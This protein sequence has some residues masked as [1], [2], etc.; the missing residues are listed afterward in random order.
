MEFLRFEIARRLRQPMVWIFFAVNFLLILGALNSENITV[1]ADLHNVNANAPWVVQ[2]Y[3]II[4]TLIGLLITTAFMNTAAV[5]DFAD[6]F[7][8]ILF[9][10][11][12]SK[13]GYLAGRLFG[14]VLMAS[15]PSL[16][17][18]LAV[19]VTG[20]DP[21]GSVKVGPTVW[22][23]YAWAVLALLVLYI[24]AG[25]LL[26]D[27]DSEHV[28]ALVDPFGFRAFALETKYWTAV[29][30]NTQYLTFGDPV[31]G[32]NRLIWVAVS[33]GIVAVAAPI[34]SIPGTTPRSSINS[35]PRSSTSSLPRVTTACIM[36]SMISSSTGITRRYSSFGTACLAAFSPNLKK[37]HRCTAST[38]PYGPTTLSSSTT[39]T[40]GA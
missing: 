2:N 40:C 11:P 28:A 8:G 37:C 15:V 7:D 25:N 36:Q 34:C 4:M 12:I 13:F 5:R 27:I 9:T 31:I 23:A 14:S 3:V 20:F 19:Y 16:G 35:G 26:R 1:G 38:K 30:R 24:V 17:V 32:L 10:K 33:F 29:E 21:F 22:G 39:S 18:S 6:K